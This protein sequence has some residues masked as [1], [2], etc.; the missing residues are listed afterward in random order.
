MATGL[1]VRVGIDSTSGAWNAPCCEQSFGFCYVPMGNSPLT[2]DYDPAYKPY[3]QVVCAFVPESAPR[4]VHWPSRL[5][6]EGHF[7]PD[8]KHLTY[9]DEANKAKRINEVFEEK[10][11][12]S[13]FIVFYAGLRSIQT[14]KLCYSIIGFYAVDRVICGPRV[15]HK[16]WHRNAHTRNRGCDDE[17]T[18]VVFADKS[19]SGRLCKHIPIGSWRNAAY[20]VTPELLERWGGLDVRDGYIQRSA[21]SPR[22]CDGHRF[23]RWFDRQGPELISQDNP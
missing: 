6:C 10:E 4:R 22:F 23:L 17:G 15:R 14:S 16:D 18:V 5:P 3:E 1:L 12:D 21:F 8:F 13:K 11:G 7:D 20:R 9:G 19:K 2:K